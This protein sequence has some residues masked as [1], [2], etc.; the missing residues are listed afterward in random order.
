MAS[1]AKLWMA[2]AV[3]SLLSMGAARAETTKKDTKTPAQRVS[4]PV[5]MVAEQQAGITSLKKVDAQRKSSEAGP[6]HLLHF[7]L[8]NEKLGT[9]AAIQLRVN[10]WSGAGRDMPLTKTDARSA[11]TWKMVNVK[12]SI[13]PRGRAETNVWVRGL[14]SLDSIDLMS[15][16]YAGRVNLEGDKHQRVQHSARSD[17]AD[18]PEVRSASAKFPARRCRRLSFE[19][20]KRPSR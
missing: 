1:Y 18:Q 3:A 14:T 16:H 19:T 6:A 15:V 13:D 17:D 2:V 12:V 11:N 7:K 8:T 10:G 4:C 20:E 5:G 9:I